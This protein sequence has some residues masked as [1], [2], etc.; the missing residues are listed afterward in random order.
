MSF[1]PVDDFRELSE[2][3]H[4]VSYIEPEVGE[5]IARVMYE[6]AR[7][8]AVKHGL[9]LQC[10]FRPPGSAFSAKFYFI[11]RVARIEGVTQVPPPFGAIQRLQAV[12][13]RIFDGP[14]IKTKDL[15]SP[16][17]SVEPPP[18]GPVE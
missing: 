11:F 7:T 9:L 5:E 18:V 17:P 1:E 8:V 12:L 6:A 2:L 14:W 16:L 15:R 13:A 4:R 3:H 10:G